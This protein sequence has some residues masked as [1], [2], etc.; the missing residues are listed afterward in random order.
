M[1]QIIKRFL[2]FV[3]ADITLVVLGLPENYTEYLVLQTTGAVITARI[4][5][6][7]GDSEVADPVQD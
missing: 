2:A 6:V 1:F 5:L 4:L 3:T 7:H